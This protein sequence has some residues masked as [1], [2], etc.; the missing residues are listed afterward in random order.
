MGTMLR[1]QVDFEPLYLPPNAA[2]L[3]WVDVGQLTQ[4]D[5]QALSCS[6]QRPFLRVDARDA[7][8]GIALTPCP[9][10]VPRWRTCGSANVSSSVLTGPK[11][12]SFLPSSAL[13]S[14]SVFMRNA[15]R[16]KRNISSRFSPSSHSARLE[17][18]QTNSHTPSNDP[19][20]HP[21]RPIPAPE[22]PTF[23]SRGRRRVQTAC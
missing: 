1:D 9:T 21:P 20:A 6:S 23:P 11:Q 2:Q 14:A 19:A 3:L 13:H 17:S 10:T 15:V 8:H 16:K 22:P 12:I 7:G 5:P 4:C 18:S